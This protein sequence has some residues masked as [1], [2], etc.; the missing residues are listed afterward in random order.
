MALTVSGQRRPAWV[1]DRWVT[2]EHGVVVTGPDVRPDDRHLPETMRFVAHA[3]ELAR[4][5]T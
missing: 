1:L 3:V 2:R 4:P 5:T